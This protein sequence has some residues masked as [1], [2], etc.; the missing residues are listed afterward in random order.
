METKK[1]K[2]SIELPKLTVAR[3]MAGWRLLSLTRFVRVQPESSVPGQAIRG[4]FPG[5][6]SPD[7]AYQETP[8]EAQASQ[9]GR[10]AT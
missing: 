4:G 8:S 3:Y 9:E 1:K 2:L 6:S 10:V 5:G 7:G